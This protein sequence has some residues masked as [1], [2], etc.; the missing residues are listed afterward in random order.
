MELLT[1]LEKTKSVVLVLAQF[2]NPII[3]PTTLNDG[4]GG[5]RWVY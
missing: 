1:A 4:G 3:E 5:S 2:S